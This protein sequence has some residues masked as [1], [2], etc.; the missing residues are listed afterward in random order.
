VIAS[1]PLLVKT[2]REEWHGLV[3][4]GRVVRSVVIRK[5]HD[6]RAVQ[7][8]EV[9]SDALLLQETADEIEVRLA[10]LHAILERMVSVLEP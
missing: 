5:H 9:V 6:V 10:I 3:P 2:G 4:R 7:V 1:A 8:L